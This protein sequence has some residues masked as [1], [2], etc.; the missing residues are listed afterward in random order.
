[1]NNLN[2][3]SKFKS[4]LFLSFFALIL[5]LVVNA[6]IG[7]YFSNKIS[8]EGVFIVENV[9]KSLD[10]IRRVNIHL[11]QF[12]HAQSNHIAA[13]DKEDLL[14]ANGVMKKKL[15]KIKITLSEFEKFI[16][17]DEIE[18]F[19]LLKLAIKNFLKINNNI[20]KLSTS[21]DKSGAQ[22]LALEYGEPYFAN[23]NKQLKEI[24]TTFF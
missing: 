9:T 21:G 5:L 7:I 3:Q 17:K 2:K 8:D 11:H 23:L 15:D 20:I 24:L 22:S 12:I 10:V 16:E 19:N 13:R 14:I 1:M 6:T 4:K 18:K